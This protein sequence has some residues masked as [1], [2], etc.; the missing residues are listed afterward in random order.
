MQQH[1]SSPSI[2]IAKRERLSYI[3]FAM[4]RFARLIFH[5][6]IDA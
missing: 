1:H 4:F 2:S 5:K 6:L 3:A